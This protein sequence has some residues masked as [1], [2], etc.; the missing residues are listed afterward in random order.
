MTTKDTTNCLRNMYIQ[1]QYFS[2]C[3]LQKFAMCYKWNCYTSDSRRKDGSSY[4]S[5]CCG[6]ISS[7]NI[8]CHDAFSC[9]MLKG[10]CSVFSPSIWKL[11]V[12]MEIV[13]EQSV[14]KSNL[15][16]SVSRLSS[17]GSSKTVF[18][19]SLPVLYFLSLCW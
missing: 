1:N 11:R 15:L 7:T 19:V 3:E 18:N 5:F 12:S 10:V 9:L 6:S 4:V 14:S 17:L 2:N 16:C 13:W 8:V